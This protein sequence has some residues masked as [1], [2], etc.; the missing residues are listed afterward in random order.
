MTDGETAT[1]AESHTEMTELVLPND[2]NTHGRALGGAVLHWMDVCGAIAAMRFATSGVV[3]AAMDHVDFK[4]PIDLGEVVVVEAYIYDTGRTSI[5]VNVEVRAEDPRTGDERD[6]TSSFFTFVAVDDDGEPTT[7]P[8]LACPTEG[9][10]RLRDAAVD[11]RAAQLE[12]LVE[13]MEG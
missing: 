6:A 4:S 11:D 2:T 8:D 1:L 10:R 9:E 7:V 3:T 5:D 13:R 12:R